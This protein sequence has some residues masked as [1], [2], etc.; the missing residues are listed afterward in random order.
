MA[1][2]VFLFSNKPAPKMPPRQPWGR[3]RTKCEWLQEKYFPGDVEFP[4]AADVL[5]EIPEHLP[6][7]VPTN[8]TELQADETEAIVRW[9]NRPL[10]ELSCRLTTPRRRRGGLY[11]PEWDQ[12]RPPD[13]EDDYDP[14]TDTAE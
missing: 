11:V 5:A 7:A 3:P 6:G 14:F 12:D 2:R 9:L 13:D 4:L 10:P 1:A 8:P